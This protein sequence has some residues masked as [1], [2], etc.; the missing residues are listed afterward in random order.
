EAAGEK[1]Q[2]GKQ[3]ET[4]ETKREP[5]TTGPCRRRAA[6]K[7]RRHPSSRSEGIPRVHHPQVNP[8]NL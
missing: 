7:R 1:R 8:A 2:Q 5:E 6:S 4:A 3:E